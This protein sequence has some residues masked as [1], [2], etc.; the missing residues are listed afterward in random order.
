[1]KKWSGDGRY[2]LP[3]R[4]VE[5]YRLWFEFLKLAATDPVLEVNYAHYAEWGDFQ[6]LSFT[7][8]WSG[9]RWRK[10]FAVDAGVRVIDE[11][12]DFTNDATAIYVRLPLSKDPKET[13]K[14]VSELLEQHGA[15]VRLKDTPTGKFALTEGYEKG[16]IKYL[17]QARVMLRLY[18]IWLSHSDL[19]QKGRLGQTAIDFIDW[20]RARDQMIKEKDYKYE[21]PLIPYSIGVFSDHYRREQKISGNSPNTKAFQRFLRKARNLGANAASGSFPGKW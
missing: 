12:E 17:P 19:Q 11:T 8:W 2:Y 4:Q 1:M 6:N 15:T 16:F 13:I 18:R 3:A 21:R 7:D 5:P 20:S 9:E 10:L 14:D